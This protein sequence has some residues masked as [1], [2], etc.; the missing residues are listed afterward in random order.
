MLEVFADELLILF[1]VSDAS[2]RYSSQFHFGNGFWLGSST[3]CSELNST[4]EE[5]ILGGLK[6]RPPFPV[7]FHVARMFLQMPKQF[8]ITVNTRLYFFIFREEW[9]L[10]SDSTRFKQLLSYPISSLHS[11]SPLSI[12]YI[13]FPHPPTDSH[14]FSKRLAHNRVP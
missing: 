10:F 11:H 6:E 9:W 2:G 5:N 12:H 1:L 7:K 13:P 8:D 4:K 3:L 14:L